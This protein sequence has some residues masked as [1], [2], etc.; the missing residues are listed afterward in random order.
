MSARRAMPSAAVIVVGTE[1]VLGLRPD[2]NGPEIARFLAAAGYAPRT[3][4]ALPDDHTHLAAYLRT[5][6]ADHDLVVVTGG[7]GPTHDDVT[8]E[9]SA[10]ALGRA[11]R[12]DSHLERALQAIAEGHREPRAAAQVLRQALV[13]EGARVLA[14][15]IG[16]APGQVVATARGSLVLL[17]GPPAEMRPMLAEAVEPFTSAEAPPPRVLG[18]VGI[19]E[20]DAQLRAERALES[21]TG[22]A[23]TVLGRPSLVDVVL[24]ADGTDGSGLAAAADDVAS[25]LA[26]H[27][28]AT[29]GATL[30]EVV[31]RDATARGIS[32]GSAESC[33][34]GLVAAALTDVAGSSAVFRGSIVAYADDIKRS[35]LSVSP[36]TLATHG[37]V[38]ETSVREMALGAREAL[39]VDVALGI[40]GIAGPAGGTAEKPVGL[41]W[42]AIADHTTVTAGP[43]TFRGDRALVRTRATVHALD[44]LRRAVTPR[45]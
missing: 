28:Y 40:T 30:A 37:A 4:F 38:S 21:H 14:P 33:T 32:I 23:L 20:S 41:V 25:A 22:V 6:I 5:A 11:L 43:V 42:F 45:S 34:G 7:L 12:P 44:L 16:T 35:A 1:L 27:C 13:I 24:I 15:S 10:D 36:G 17:P 8:R 18:C 39:G 26:P 19:R 2:T 31:I 9:A 3:L 29:D